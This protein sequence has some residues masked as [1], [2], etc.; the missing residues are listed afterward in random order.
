[1]LD[2]QEHW[3]LLYVGLTRA[4][5]RLVIAGLKPK[6]KDGVLPENCWHRSVERALVSLG[7]SQVE[8]PDWGTVLRYRGAVEPA[9]IRAKP[10]PRALTPSGD[11]GLGGSARRLPKRGRRSPWRRRRS[12]RTRKHRRRR[13]RRN[14]SRRN[15][16]R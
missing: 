1:M 14:A 16:A 2:L 9:A 6:T 11:P 7:A 5:E 8:D 3:R 15:A 13:A 4:E 12:P 10:Q